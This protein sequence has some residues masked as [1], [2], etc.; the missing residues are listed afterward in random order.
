MNLYP[1]LLNTPSPE[2][3]FPV[4]CK[5]YESFQYSSLG[6]DNVFWIGKIWKESSLGWGFPCKTLIE[7]TKAGNLRSGGK[8][9]R[10][11][12]DEQSSGGFCSNVLQNVVVSLM[13]KTAQYPFYYIF[14]ISWTRPPLLWPQTHLLFAQTQVL[15]TESLTNFCS[16]TCIRE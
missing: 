2:D 14:Q 12:V 15:G 9:L 4:F 3:K 11:G 13:K 1:P 5:F 7:S 10:S 6:W 16:E 8:V